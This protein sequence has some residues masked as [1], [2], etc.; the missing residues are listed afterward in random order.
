MGAC[1]EGGGG[2]PGVEGFFDVNI[3]EDVDAGCWR[4]QVGGMREVGDRS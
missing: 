4:G 3:I 2:F 1:R